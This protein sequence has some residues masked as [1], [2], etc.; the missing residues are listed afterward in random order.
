LDGTNQYLYDAEGNR[1]AKGT[2]GGAGGCDT[3]TGF[4]A[5]STYGLDSSASTSTE[6]D[7]SGNWVR[8]DVS[9]TGEHVATYK[10]DGMG[11][12]FQLSDWLGNRR[13]PDRLRW[14]RR[15]RVQPDQD[16][17]VSAVMSALQAFA[18]R[19]PVRDDSLSENSRRNGPILPEG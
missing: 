19:L 2:T 11:V 16:E 10:N 9:A 8:T 14:R 13:G 12:Y 17:E 4:T 6:Y 18:A 15:Y 1:L 3:S 5:T 7:Q